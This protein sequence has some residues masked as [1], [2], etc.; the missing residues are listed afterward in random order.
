M[1]GFGGDDKAKSREGEGL[2]DGDVVAI[3]RCGENKLASGSHAGGV[4]REF[5]I[6]LGIG[7]DEFG[8]AIR[9]CAAQDA[10]GQRFSPVVG[11][12]QGC[13]DFFATE[14]N[15]ARDVHGEFD[16]FQ[17]EFAHFESAL[18]LQGFLVLAFLKCGHR[19][20]ADARC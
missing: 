7:G 2:G 3:E 1:A 13:F 19:V 17:L 6:S 12:L 14:P 10:V 4:E 20:L 18:E 9:Q 8:A 5:R 15:A 16:F 11:R